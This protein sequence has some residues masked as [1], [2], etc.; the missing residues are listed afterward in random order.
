M[1]SNNMLRRGFVLVVCTACGLAAAVAADSSAKVRPGASGRTPMQRHTMADR[2]VK[3]RPTAA[4]NIATRPAAAR[5][6][7]AKPA[8]SQPA[9]PA[10]IEVDAAEHDFGQVQ[11]GTK[12]NHSFKLTNAGK[13]E[14]KITNVKPTCGCTVAGDYPKTLA[15]GASGMFPFSL[16]APSH[17]G[18]FSKGINI[19]TSDQ[20]KPNLTLTL[21]GTMR[22][23]ILVQPPNIY[24]GS[25]FGTQSKTQVVAISNNTDKPLK[26]V[27]DPL[28]SGKGWTFD[29]VEKTPGQKYELT[30]SFNPKDLPPGTTPQTATLLTNVSAQHEIRVSATAVVRSRIEVEPATLTIY[31]SSSQPAVVRTAASQP[32]GAG[33]LPI[34][35]FIR[36]QNYGDKPVK[37]LSV[38]ADD[39]AVKATLKEQTLGRMYVVNVTM[40]A[41]LAAGKQRAITVKT[42]DAEKPTIRIPL[43]IVQPVTQ[44]AP[45]EQLVGKPSPAFDLTTLDGKKVSTTSLKGVVAVLNFFAPNCGYCKKQLPRLEALRQT[46]EAKGIRFVNVG[47]TMGRTPTTRE[48][49]VAKLQELGVKA[50]AALDANNTVGSQF[51]VSSYPMMFVLGKSGKVEAVN[52]GNKQDLETLVKKQLDGLL[53]GKTQ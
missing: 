2:V 18:P 30:A 7:T 9:G 12:L 40:P 52:K 38:E 4:R 21:K 28:S 22:P 48:A 53:S 47:E 41:T 16:T 19:T 10:A 25:V 45:V 49:M 13:A 6:A 31:P 32:A 8:T 26:V 20:A 34:T 5:S 51:R 3:A 42:D 11:S 50:E 46:Y 29:L 33:Q 24:L 35:R 37:V 1:Y 17:A 15:P 43:V 23:Q 27:L 36:V 44:P 39:E 14:I